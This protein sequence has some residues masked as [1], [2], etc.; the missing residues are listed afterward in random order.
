[1]G[2]H[3]SGKNATTRPNHGKFFG[4]DPLVGGRGTPG[5]GAKRNLTHGRGHNN[6][7]AFVHQGGPFAGATQQMVPKLPN[8]GR[9][10]AMMMPPPPFNASFVP[11]K[12]SAC[13][14]P[15][16]ALIDVGVW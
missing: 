8:I 3:S 7:G 16:Y 11:I 13:A 15:A 1:M 6:T 4:A 10:G 2:S 9:L 5:G 12:C 14:A